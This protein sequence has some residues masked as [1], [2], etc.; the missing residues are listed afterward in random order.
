MPTVRSCLTPTW[1][2]REQCEMLRRAWAGGQ[3]HRGARGGS[4]PNP[5]PRCVF[6]PSPP[7]G[8][9][10]SP[11]GSRGPTSRLVRRFICRRDAARHVRVL[12]ISYVTGASGEEVGRLVADRLGFRY[13]DDEIGCRRCKALH[14]P[15]RARAWSLTRPASPNED[16]IARAR[17]S[18]ASVTR[19]VRRRGKLAVADGFRTEAWAP[20][21][22]LPR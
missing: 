4:L 1:R 17:R 18:W 14:R 7:P 8:L 3:S 15:I 20:V 16:T 6:E 2:S 10:P 21:G 22:S 9:P 12:C 13:V 11:N 5:S 19:T